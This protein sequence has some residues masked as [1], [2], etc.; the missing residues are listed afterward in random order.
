MGLERLSGATAEFLEMWQI[1]FFGKQPFRTCNDGISLT[2]VPTLPSRLIGKGGSVSAMFLGQTPVTYLLPAQENITPVT[3]KPISY[4]LVDKTG[5]CTLIESEAL[6]DETAR[7]IRDGQYSSI[8][9]RI[10]RR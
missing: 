4:Q 6:P 3:H 1:L 8:T 9:V 2:L 10:G 5:V 7:L